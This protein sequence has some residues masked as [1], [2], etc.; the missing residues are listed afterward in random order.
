MDAY[1]L[2]VFYHGL[3]LNSQPIASL[4]LSALKGGNNSLH[5]LLSLSPS[6]DFPKVLSLMLLPIEIDICAIKVLVF[7]LVEVFSPI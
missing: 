2:S 1:Q 5:L 3:T 4:T 6:R 7:G